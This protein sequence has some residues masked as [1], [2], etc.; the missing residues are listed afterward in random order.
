M[1][2]LERQLYLLTSVKLELHKK[3]SIAKNVMNCFFELDLPE[4]TKVTGLRILGI[5]DAKQIN[6]MFTYSIG[7]GSSKDKLQRIEDNVQRTADLIQ[8]LIEEQANETRLQTEA[9]N[10]N[11][12]FAP[13]S[14]Q[15]TQDRKTLDPSPY[16]RY[17]TVGAL[18]TLGSS[19]VSLPIIASSAGWLLPSVA[20]GVA[21]AAGAVI[22]G[23]AFYL[24]LQAYLQPKNEI[25]QQAFSPDQDNPKDNP[26]CCI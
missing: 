4:S 18:V 24:S 13:S 11:S 21:C 23:L 9:V 3:V 16:Q 14:D 17:L 5:D 7:L 22:L 10:N 25:N 20:L 12:F 15:G 8:Y 6:Q 26:T 1:Q 2:N 19:L